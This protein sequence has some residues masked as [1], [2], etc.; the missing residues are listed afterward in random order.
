MLENNSFSHSPG[1]KY[2]LAN[3]MKSA[4][5]I[6]YDMGKRV[7]GEFHR[8][9]HTN[10][11]PLH[12]ISAANFLKDKHALGQGRMHAYIEHGKK[13][14]QRPPTSYEF[15]SPD[16][17]ILFPSEYSHSSDKDNDLC[18]KCDRSRLKKRSPRG[19]AQVHYGLI[20]SANTLLRD[21][22][23]RDNMRESLGVLCFEMEAAG[24]MNSFPCLVI[25][26]ISDYADDHK[27]NAWQAYAAL[28]AAAYTKD[29]LMEIQPQHVSET[30]FA[31][32]A[33]KKCMSTTLY[34]EDGSESRF[35]QEA[36][37]FSSAL[38]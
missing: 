5:V 33:L 35:K 29:R 27:N 31:L 24:L 21:G 2:A 20:A 10:K 30:E 6:Q 28:T 36:F 32:E 11:P 3:R 16:Y 22:K 12:L 17:D 1:P 18:E 34:L 8:D 9:S 7:E 23:F 26:G 4:G 37:G 14:L 15:P 38:Y 19:N 13:I 25:R